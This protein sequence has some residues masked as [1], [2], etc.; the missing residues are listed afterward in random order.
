[1]VK[2][3]IG[4][5]I[6][7]ISFI[8]PALNQVII[9]LFQKRLSMGK[10]ALSEIISRAALLIGIIINEKLGYGLNGLLV[11]SVVS[12]FISFVLN[13]IFSLK[14]AFIKL[15]FDLSLWKKIINRSW[16]LAIT[17]VLNLIYMRA[18]TLILSLFRGSAVVGLYG[19]A[20]KIIDVLTTLPFMFAGLILPILTSAWKEDNHGYFKQVLQKSFDFM[21]IIAIP[22]VIGA[23]FLSG[24]IMTFVAGRDFAVSGEILKVLILAVAAI[25]LGTMFSHAVIAI[26]QQKK[27]IVFYV[28]TSISSLIAYLFFIPRYSYFGAAGVTIYSEVLIAIFSAYCIF[29]YSH[30]IPSLIVFLKSLGAGILMGAF[31]FFIPQAFY[32]KSLLGLFLILILA[33]LIYLIVLY[34]FG[35]IKSEDIKSILKKQKGGASQTYGSEN[36]F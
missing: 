13:Y 18:D 7:A 14:F 26:N 11:V 27:M 22:L 12:A 15:D 9:G 34:F 31:I 19:A 20:Y 23:Q 17:I 25:F 28:F 30:F 5:L 4:V 1:M 2:G 16:P 32:Q 36:N 8:F 35:G 29:K 10:S 33:S 24:S 6:T 3:K 21:A